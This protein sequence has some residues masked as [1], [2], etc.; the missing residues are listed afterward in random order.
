MLG[1]N[2]YIVEDEF[3]FVIDAFLSHGNIVGV[4]IWGKIWGNNI[5]RVVTNFVI[6]VLKVP[7]LQKTIPRNGELPATFCRSVA[8][9]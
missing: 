4:T 3:F 1:R 7:K 8:W 6:T 9:A 2:L 5:C